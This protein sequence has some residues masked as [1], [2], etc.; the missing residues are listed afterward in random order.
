MGKEVLLTAKEV[1]FLAKYMEAVFIDYD[2]IAAMPDIQKNYTLN[3]QQALENLENKEVIEEDFSGNV[4]IPEEIIRLFEPVFFGRKESKL[5]NGEL[6]RFHILGSRI[7]M[8]RPD[9]EDFIFSMVVDDDLE[10]FLK[11]T[12]HI[13]CS[14]VDRGVSKQVFTGDQLM[15]ENYRKEAIRLLKG[16][17]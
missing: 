3:E 13:E 4:E 15:Q 8:S 6:I 16:G 9:Q 17:N 11:G 10:E 14:D 2:Y 7:T 5:N 12:V 1:Y